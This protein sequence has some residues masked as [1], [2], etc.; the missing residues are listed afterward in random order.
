MLST[1]VSNELGSE[2]MMTRFDS[3]LSS[4]IRSSFNSVRMSSRVGSANTHCTFN[5][6]TTKITDVIMN[7]VKRLEIVFL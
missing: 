1:A 3:I 6:T 7:R 4:L 5:E 2:F